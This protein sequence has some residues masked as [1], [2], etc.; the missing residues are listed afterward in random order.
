[1]GFDVTMYR[2]SRI[3][4]LHPIAFSLGIEEYV[5]NVG[6]SFV[7][8]ENG[9]ITAHIYNSGWG[10]GEYVYSLKDASGAY[11]VSD[12]VFVVAFEDALLY[13]GVSGLPSSTYSLEVYPSHAP[14]RQQT[15]EFSLHGSLM[16][17]D[18]NSDGSLNV[19]D[20]VIM[21]NLILSSDNSNPASDLNQDGMCNILDIVILVNL[22]LEN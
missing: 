4:N 7:E 1:M 5:G 11:I 2:S 19:L 22:I 14:E 8:P 16:L 15:F 3:Q 17:G 12:S 13:I 21:A 18:M 10:G 9:H 6:E 20:V